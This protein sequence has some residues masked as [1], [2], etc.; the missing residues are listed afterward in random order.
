MSEKANFALKNCNGVPNR[1][2]RFFALRK[3]KFCI[4][5]TEI[6]P[7]KWTFFTQKNRKFPQCHGV[8]FS[9]IFHAK[10]VNSTLQRWSENSI[11]NSTIPESRIRGE[12]ELCL[13]LPLHNE[14]V[15]VDGGWKPGWGQN[16]TSPAGRTPSSH[17]DSYRQCPTTCES[18]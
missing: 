1:L 4:Q 18:C 8:G 3:W 11:L 16:K 10:L 5:E 12:T 2:H 17:V 6:V 9:A 13:D 7:Q 15:D 14:N